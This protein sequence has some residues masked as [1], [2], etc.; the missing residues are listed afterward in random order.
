MWNIRKKVEE[1]GEK[2]EMQKKRWELI[3]LFQKEIV[4]TLLGWQIHTVYIIIFISSS[5]THSSSHCVFKSPIHLLPFLDK[6][7]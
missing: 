3:V 7:K 6:Q 2:K 4:F 5:D 1:E